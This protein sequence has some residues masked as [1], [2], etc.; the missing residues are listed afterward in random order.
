M[1]TLASCKECEI[2]NCTTG[3]TCPQ[4]RDKQKIFWHLTNTV[5]QYLIL[6]LNSQDKQHKNNASKCKKIQSNT[7][8]H[9][10]PCTA[11]DR[12]WGFWKVGGPRFRDS[13]HMN[14]ARLSA[15]CTGR[16]I[17]VRACVD[18]TATVRSKALCQWKIP[19]T[20]LWIKPATS[21]SIAQCLNQRH[22]RMLPDSI[23]QALINK[24][25]QKF[26]H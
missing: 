1:N 14:V 2:M 24:N 15:L 9:S 22:D 20:P 8:W 5:M 6:F 7:K 3:C 18:P 19:V 13:Q 17:S 23:W 12:P 26:M 4:C 16:L 25:N 10:N 11:L 21:Q